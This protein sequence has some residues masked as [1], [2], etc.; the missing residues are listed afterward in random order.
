MPLK[1]G[2]S[3]REQTKIEQFVQVLNEPTINLNKLEDLCFHGIPDEESS[4]K[5]KCWK[6]LLG[7]L[8]LNRRKDV[9]ILFLLN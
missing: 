3:K 6:I 7:Y 4:L 8:P 2:K 5:P 9:I 1:F